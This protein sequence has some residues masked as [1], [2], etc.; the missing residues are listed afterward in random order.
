M[1]KEGAEGYINVPIEKIK[2]K[3]TTDNLSIT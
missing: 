1:S 3:T 2:K